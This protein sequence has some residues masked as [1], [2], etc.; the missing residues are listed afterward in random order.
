[1]VRGVVL[2]ACRA[3]SKQSRITPTE[4]LPALTEF[5]QGAD[6]GAEGNDGGPR[7]RQEGDAGEIDAQGDHAAPASGNHPGAPPTAAG[8]P[9]KEP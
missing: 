2:P 1:M 5:Q 3:G 4:D 6:H 8:Q 7:V 9:E